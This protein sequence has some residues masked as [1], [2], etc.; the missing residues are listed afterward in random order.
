MGS[1]LAM[2]EATG[3][4]P[5]RTTTAQGE[6]G[7]AYLETYPE[8]ADIFEN[9]DSIVPRERGTGVAS[10]KTLWENAMG[11][12][13]LEDLDVKETLESYLPQMNAALA[14]E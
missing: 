2:V 11:Q 9:L 5:T 10:M 8:Y 12:A 3:Y 7:Q 1:T 14:G 6:M 13:M 4:L